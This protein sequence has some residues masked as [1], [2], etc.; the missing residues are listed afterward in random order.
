MS[1]SCLPLYFVCPPPSTPH[2]YTRTHTNTHTYT[3]TLL[4]HRAIP[5][6]HLGSMVYT[7]QYKV[8]SDHIHVFNCETHETFKQS[9]LSVLVRDRGH[10]SIVV[11]SRS[12]LVCFS[13]DFVSINLL[14]PCQF[15]WNFRHF[16]FQFILVIHGWGRYFL[17]YC[18]K[19]NVSASYWR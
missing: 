8:C 10:I 4:T 6:F 15:Q 1:V 7:L 11:L 9:K 2:T 16:I 14:S 17:L 5:Y 18:P 19:M 13:C 12:G 3:R